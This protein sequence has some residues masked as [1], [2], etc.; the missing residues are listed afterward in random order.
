M[1]LLQL[2]EKA[3]EQMMSEVKNFDMK[4]FLALMDVVNETEEE[5]LLDHQD[6]KLD[7]PENGQD[8][9]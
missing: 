6:L 7:L 8:K 5:E 9:R 1:A 2:Q 4:V 3:M